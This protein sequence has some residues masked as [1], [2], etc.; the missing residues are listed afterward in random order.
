ME[1][2]GSKCER[3]KVD[4]DEN[5]K[6]K[7][8][9]IIPVI[10]GGDNSESNCSLLCKNCHRIAPNIRNKDELLIYNNY[11]LRFASFK[12]A[13]QFY[14]VETRFDLSIKAALDVSKVYKNK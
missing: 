12:E 14:N 8:Y 2:T 6:G 10:F 3:C 5:F 9:H 4:F 13:A 1:R 11:F 7:F